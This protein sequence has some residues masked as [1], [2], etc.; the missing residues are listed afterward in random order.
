MGV[1]RL[2]PRIKNEHN[3]ICFFDP[4][5]MVDFIFIFFLL[6]FDVVVVV[7]VGFECECNNVE[8][9]HVDD[10]ILEFDGDGVE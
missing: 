3:W 5:Q 6:R 10:D 1:I 8:F 9:V 4:G 2:P 7:L